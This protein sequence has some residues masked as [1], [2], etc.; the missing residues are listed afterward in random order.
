MVDKS[1]IPF[2]D[3]SQASRQH[4]KQ[5]TGS[6]LFEQQGI[7]IFPNQGLR[8]SFDP[9][10]MDFYVLALNRYGSADKDIGLV[11][12]EI[13]PKTIHFLA[14]GTLHTLSNLSD[15][16][17][18]YYICFQKA[19][20]DQYYA[21]K[22]WLKALGFY[23]SE[24]T[25]LFQLD[26]ETFDRVEKCVL[27]IALEQK[28]QSEDAYPVI[29]SCLH[30]VHLEAHRYYCMQFL[31]K[32]KRRSNAHRDS[33]ADT[34]KKMVDKQFIQKRQVAEYA[35]DM[36]LSP[37]YLSELIHQSTGA[38]PLYWIHK[39]IFL[40]TKYYLRHTSLSLKEIAMELDFSSSAHFTKF[41]K[42]MSKGITPSQ[43]RGNLKN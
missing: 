17:D 1:P 26:G 22:T 28:Q 11:H 12:Y 37:Q 38:S 14:P 29:W 13:K 21:D 24:G 43:F 33:L 40:E 36:S 32:E 7:A 6:I 35:Q 4:R 8:E 30:Q 2:Y 39:R 41:F 5:E 34:F 18:G 3:F 25:P 15:D 27:R 23:S 10:R 20:Y 16:I 42:K 31:P 19:F 9:N